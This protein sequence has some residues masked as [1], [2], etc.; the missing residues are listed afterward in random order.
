MFWKYNFL[1]GGCILH[2]PEIYAH[3]YKYIWVNPFDSTAAWSS[4]VI[5]LI[6][7]N[8]KEC[9]LLRLKVNVMFQFMHH[10]GTAAPYL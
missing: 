2:S 5:F 8:R 10:N 1:G 3:R 6:E 9:M 4:T 7:I